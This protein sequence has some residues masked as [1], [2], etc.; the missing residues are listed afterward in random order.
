M[1]QDREAKRYSEVDE[2]AGEI[3]SLGK[4]YNIPIPYNEFI[5]NMVKSIEETY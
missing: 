2:F 1:L 4:Q 3:I 5:Y